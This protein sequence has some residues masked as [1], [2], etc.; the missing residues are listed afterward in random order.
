M[1]AFLCVDKANSR[2]ELCTLL[3]SFAVAA[4]YQM[5]MEGVRI[6]SMMEM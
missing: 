5:E 1:I 2:W 3:K 4:V 6:D